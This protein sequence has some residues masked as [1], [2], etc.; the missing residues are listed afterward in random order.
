[1][2]ATECG[3]ADKSSG[4]VGELVMQ[5]RVQPKVGWRISTIYGFGAIAS[6]AKSVPITTLLMLYYNQVVGVSALAVSAVLTLSLILDAI[7]DPLIGQI[8]DTYRSGWGRRLPFMY[9]SMIP[10]TVL[11]I[12]L[13]IPPLGWSEWE[14]TLYLALCLIGVRF[15]DTFFELPHTALI[16]ELTSDYNERTKLFT[17]RYLFEAI[18][19]TAISMLA[20][21]VFMKEK[22]DGSGGLLSPD[23]YTSYAWFCGAL[24]FFAM[25]ACT[26]G[27]HRRI[28]QPTVLPPRRLSVRAHVLEMAATLKSRSFAVLA[29]SAVFISIGSGLGSALSI[30]WLMFY[31][32]FTQAEMSLMTIPVMLGMFLTVSAPAIGRRFGKRNAA[33]ILLWIHAVSVSVPLLAMLL[34]LVPQSSTVLASLVAAQAMLGAAAMTMVLITLASMISDLVEEA[35][36]RTGRRSEG[37]LLAANSFVRKATQGFGTLAAGLILTLV[38]FPDGAERG[39]VPLVTMTHMAWIYLVVQLALISLTTLILLQHRSDKSTHEANLR[40]V[41]ESGPDD[42]GLLLGEAASVEVRTDPVVA[43]RA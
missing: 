5:D 41:R 12:L 27:L 35:Q 39:R 13:W 14:L 23:G 42:T 9:A 11:F 28:A 25:L 24:I 6:G 38:A 16:P 32:R 22:P 36:A 17:V 33:L 2:A 26:A 43:T 31:Y 10:V 29:G 1:M 18:T 3:A 30:Y 19:G 34:G 20:Y 7:F 15:F 4:R 37:L 8:S 40:R 21:N